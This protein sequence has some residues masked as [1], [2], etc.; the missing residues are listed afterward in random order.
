MR[1]LWNEIKKILTWKM[2]LLLVFVNTVLYFLLIAFHIEH[3]PNGRPA[4]DS[5][6]IGIEMIEKYGTEYDEEEFLD[7]K[8]TYEKQFSEANQYVLSQNELVDAGITSYEDLRNFEGDNEEVTAFRNKVLF[9]EE[10]DVFWEL[11]ERERLNEY[12]NMKEETLTNYRVNA[13]EAQ[14]VRFDELKE[15]RH[16]QVYTE[17]V[18]QNYR[19]YIFN[20]AIVILLSIILVISPAILRDRSRQL[21]DLQ[22]TT[23]KGRELY[24]TKILAG[25]LSSFLVISGLLV[26][27]MSIYSFNNTSMYF[28]IPVHMF[29]ADYAWY[30]PTF[31]QY[32]L[33]TILAIYVLGM[34]TSLIAMS[35]SS[36]AP[37]F[38]ALIGL[39]VP[40]TFLL[41]AFILGYLL[42]MII[43][44]WLPQWVVP[45]AYGVLLVGSI[46]SIFFLWKREKKRD[47]VL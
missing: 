47:I 10:N 25:I 38:I 45:T 46:L 30:D 39:Q 12:Y 41:L 20:V 4:L 44:I 23:K 36:I 35:F 28:P 32:I 5:Y 22:Y 40:Y 37:N 6:R 43:S 15:A 42:K 19:E 8:Q 3:F 21:L 16:F 27:Y 7:F 26:V 31:F 17:V 2:L 33:L 18:I 9:E 11:Q 29:I 34:I 24:K 1:I 13:T 14:V